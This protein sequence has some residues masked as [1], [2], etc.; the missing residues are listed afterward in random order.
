[1]N[2]TLVR[3]EEW[4][5]HDPDPRTREELRLLVEAAHNGYAPAQ[6]DLDERFVG[7]LEFGTAGLRGV[8]GAGESRMNL[9]VVIRTTFGLA[10]Y[11]LA[12]PSLEVTRRGVA[13]GYDGRRQSRE[14]ARAAVG[15]LAAL[16]IPTIN[17]EGVCP[18]PLLAFAVTRV[19]A[20]AGIMVTASHNPPEYNGYKV[21]WGNGAQIIP[22]H[23]RG[24][25]RAI[26][27]APPAD[28]IARLDFAEARE[29]GLCRLFPLDLDLAYLDGIGALSL[30]KHGARDAAIV[31]T[32][33]HGV[34]NR[35][36]REA[37]RRAGFSNVV[38][39]PEQAEP[40]AEFPTVAFPNPEEKGALDLSFALA[41]RL[42]ADLVL[43]SD[44][45]ADRLAAAIRTV[46]ATEPSNKRFTQLTGNQ[47]GVLLGHYLL[48][49]VPRPTTASPSRPACRRRSSA[50][51]R[52]PSA[53]ATR[54]R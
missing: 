6:H 51:S 39:V 27:E 52:A 49:K 42:R 28:T 45:D 5:A 43:A 26:D 32:P 25:A 44:P 50:R 18:T 35:L 8:L 37:F 19:G 23:D 7:P 31:Y 11:L 4:I 14:F 22:P 10:K 20:A 41:D 13:I 33:L 24:I 21:Y 1:M 3:A 46:P 30:T 47:V 29:R 36:A 34:G 38:S 17:S 15:V 54:R 48:T 12:D 40:N 16:G 53:C 2:S 9:A